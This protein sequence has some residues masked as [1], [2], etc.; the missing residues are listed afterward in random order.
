[1]AKGLLQSA[2]NAQEGL[3]VFFFL[4]LF[5]KEVLSLTLYKNLRASLT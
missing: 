5:L 1:M 3:S 2:W 4:L